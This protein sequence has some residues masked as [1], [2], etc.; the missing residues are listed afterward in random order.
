MYTP[1][2]SKGIPGKK[3]DSGLSLTISSLLLTAAIVLCIYTLERSM[4]ISDEKKETVAQN[5]SSHK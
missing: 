4:Y 2:R 3:N 1:E 5:S